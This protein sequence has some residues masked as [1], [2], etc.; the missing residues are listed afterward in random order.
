M[1]AARGACPLTTGEPAATPDTRQAVI[2]P[3]SRIALGSL[4]SGC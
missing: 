1:S 4:V 3:P 2:G